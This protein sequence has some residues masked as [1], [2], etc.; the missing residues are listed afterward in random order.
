MKPHSIFSGDTVQP[1]TL[2]KFESMVVRAR[3]RHDQE[4]PGDSNAK[5]GGELSLGKWNLWDQGRELPSFSLVVQS[6]GH[7]CYFSYYI[8]HSYFQN[9]LLQ[10]HYIIEVFFIFK[11]L[12]K[13]L[14]HYS[15]IKNEF[16]FIMYH[17][18][19]YFCHSKFLL[20]IEKSVLFQALCVLI[21]T[22]M[23]ISC[24]SKMKMLT[25]EYLISWSVTPCTMAYWRRLYDALMC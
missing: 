7:S 13:Y 15:L 18:E 12:F 14:H 22:G 6:L 2:T 9:S 19:V 24:C 20:I 21:S 23:Q 4:V 8:S 10:N 25:T 1:G 5:Q 3:H 16:L 17:V 11:N